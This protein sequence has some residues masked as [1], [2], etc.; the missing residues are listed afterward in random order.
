MLDT[1]EKA[2]EKRKNETSLSEIG[3]KMFISEQTQKFMTPYCV[4]FFRWDINEGQVV[5]SLKIISP[6]RFTWF[7]L[8]FPPLS[9]WFLR[10]KLARLEE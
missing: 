3:Y 10:E 7:I 8:Q 4:P 9:C 6:R 5:T 2:R 1:G